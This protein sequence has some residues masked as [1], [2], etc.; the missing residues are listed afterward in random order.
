MAAWPPFNLSILTGLL[1]IHLCVASEALKRAKQVVL[2]MKVVKY[3]NLT[4]WL[5][6]PAPPPKPKP[7]PSQVSEV[8][9][10]PLNWGKLCDVV[11]EDDDE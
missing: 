8:R 2:T 7:K 4:H 3:L 9:L 5:L 11:D 10:A 6:P 1:T